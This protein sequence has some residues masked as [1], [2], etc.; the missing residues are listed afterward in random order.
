MSLV[1]DVDNVKRIV[2]E[3][4]HLIFKIR[5]YFLGSA[6]KSAAKN[7]RINQVSSN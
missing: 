1:A 3:S 4:N 7:M 6:L 2:D 5:I